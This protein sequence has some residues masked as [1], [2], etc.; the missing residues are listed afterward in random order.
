MKDKSVD[1]YQGFTMTDIQYVVG[2]AT[3]PIGGGQKVIVHVCNDI[4]AWG[5]GFVMALSKKWKEPESRYR[6]WYRSK[7]G[8]FLGAVQYVQVEPELFVAN[9]IG[10]QGIYSRNGAVPVRYPAI[11]R[12]LSQIANWC[13][14]NGASFHAPRFGAGLAGGDWSVIEDIIKQEICLHDIPVTIYDLK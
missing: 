6:S 4:G 8:F 5:A 10:Q 11:Q 12:G 13:R 14:A 9:M 2:D 3:A 1:L 7:V